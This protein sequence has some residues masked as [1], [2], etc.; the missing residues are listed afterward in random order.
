[1]SA[2]SN[3]RTLQS[4]ELPLQMMILFPVLWENGTPK[5]ENTFRYGGWGLYHSRYPQPFKPET[6]SPDRDTSESTNFIV[7]E[8]KL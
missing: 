3:M 5:L 1:M 4:R 8:L 2:I 7:I 6:E